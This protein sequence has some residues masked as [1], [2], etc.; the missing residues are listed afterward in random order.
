M[1]LVEASDDQKKFI[2]LILSTGD[3]LICQDGGV[4]EYEYFGTIEYF[5]LLL[6]P[7]KQTEFNGSSIIIDYLPKT[8]DK[9]VFIKIS[10][11]IGFGS[12]VDSDLE[13]NILSSIANRSIVNFAN[14]DDLQITH[15]GTDTIN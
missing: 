5:K 12:F 14:Q 6:N 7:Y 15:E 13:K 11:I 10:H 3:C 1:K 4:Y 9:F 8:K 2:R